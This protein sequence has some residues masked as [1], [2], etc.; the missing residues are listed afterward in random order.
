MSNPIR[1]QGQ[2][3]RK[4]FDEG[5]VDSL[6]ADQKKEAAANYASVNCPYG[7]GDNQD[8]WLAGFGGAAAPKAA[9]TAAKKG[10]K[11]AAA[12]PAPAPAVEPTASDVM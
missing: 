11:P 1:E 7:P 4:N 12:K 8:E 9:T 6:N 5:L 10:G 2:S 3:A